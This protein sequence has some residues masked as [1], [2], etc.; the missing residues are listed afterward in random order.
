MVNDNEF[1]S[2]Q[3]MNLHLNDSVA[4]PPEEDSLDS[5]ISNTY[6]SVYENE[7]S[8][9]AEK[10]IHGSELAVNGNLKIYQLKSNEWFTDDQEIR[11]LQL[12]PTSGMKKEK[13]HYVLFLMGS[14]LNERST[15]IDGIINYVLGVEWNDSFRFKITNGLHSRKNCITAYS[16]GHI[17]GM[18]INYDLTIIDSPWPIGSIA[19]KVSA[20]TWG[21]GRFLNHPHTRTLHLDHVNALC[22]VTSPIEFTEEQQHKPFLDSSSFLFGWHLR[23]SVRILVNLSEGVEPEASQYSKFDTS[24]LFAPYLSSGTH[25]LAEWDSLHAH[26]NKFFTMVSSMPSTSLEQIRQLLDNRI[27]LE[28]SFKVKFVKIDLK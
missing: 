20:I 6:S 11:W 5:R 16:I 21:L 18:K 10:F 9:T 14:I 26:F 17:K 4:Q 13:P 19:E 23:D 3:L 15:L 24:V 1:V 7:D 28:Q 8:Y 27:C 12:G 2:S 22:L 25:S